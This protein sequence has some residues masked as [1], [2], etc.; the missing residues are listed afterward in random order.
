MRRRTILLIM[1]CL[2][3][4]LITQAQTPIAFPLTSPEAI[5]EAGGETSLPADQFISDDTGDE[6][7]QGAAFTN[8]ENGQYIRFPA[9][10]INLLQGEVTFWYRPDYDAASEDDSIHALV[11]VGDVYAAPRLELFEGDRLTLNIIDPNFNYFSTGAA[12]RAPLWQAGDWVSIRAVWNS[13]AEPAD[14]IQLYVNEERV[15]EG[16][17]GAGWNIP[18]TLETVY[19][20]SGNAEGAFPANGLLSDVVF[21]MESNAEA[22]APAPESSTVSFSAD[23]IDNTFRHGQLVEAVDI[24]SDSDVDILL[25]SS[26]NDAVYLYLNDGAGAF[27]RVNVAAENSIVAM[28]TATA[29]YNGDGALDVAAVGLFDRGCAFCA[30]GEVMWY[31]NPGENG[32]TW[33]EN[34][35]TERLWGARSIAAADMDADGDP[36]VV[37]GTVLVDGNGGGLYWYQNR[38]TEWD[39]PLPID[40]DLDYV[41][42]VLVTDVAGD[43]LPDVIAASSSG[44]EII[45]YENLGAIPE[46]TFIRRELGTANRPYDLALLPVGEGQQLV[47]TS[48]D[49]VLLFDPGTTP[50]ELWTQTIMDANY[51]VNASARVVV[52]DLNGD[53]LPDLAITAHNRSAALTDF[54]WYRAS[55]EGTWSPED[56][57]PAYPGLTDVASG[58]FNGDGRL[59]L[60]GSTYS[61]SG[62]SDQ[63]TLWLNT[64]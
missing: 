23:V 6:E 11:V 51:G 50:G 52:V 39:G 45:W 35:I 13:S 34:T 28:Q 38:G 18:A 14:A 8:E 25:T 12:Y 16:S 41:E 55:A 60:I 21:T 43:G 58:D 24:D 62:S 32:D 4:A 36:D 19:I 53:A 5:A 44:T 3:L 46:V 31:A 49:G 57:T 15:D 27:S 20:G 33:A 30:P 26:L 40:A 63:L 2:W 29:D 10:D 7:R 64:P 61:S 54:R 37:V 59:D 1:L 9:A 48:D 56:I 47:V 42:S 17:T 22:A